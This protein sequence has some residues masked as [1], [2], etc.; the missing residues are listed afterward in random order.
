MLSERRR[1][2]VRRMFESGITSPG[3]TVG[4]G[5]AGRAAGRAEGAPAAAGPD[6]DA[7][8]PDHDSMSRLMMRP[9]GPL[10]VTDASGKI[11][12]VKISYLQD[13]TAQMLEYSGAKR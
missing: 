4:S 13:L 2:I 8:A 11:T 3:R 6:R 9:P 12:D 10:P 5:G 1:A 7:A